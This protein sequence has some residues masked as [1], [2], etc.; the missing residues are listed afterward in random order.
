M[1]PVNLAPLPGSV[2]GLPAAATPAGSA[3][4]SASAACAA[5]SKCTPSTGLT[6]ITSPASRNAAP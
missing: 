6:A 4:A 3:T 5:A 1:A 2:A